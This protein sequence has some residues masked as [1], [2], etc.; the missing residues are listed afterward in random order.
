M[1]FRS[2]S[3]SFRGS[4]NLHLSWG[5][6]ERESKQVIVSIW[7]VGLSS[8]EKVTCVPSLESTSLFPTGVLGTQ[9]CTGI[10]ESLGAPPHL[11]FSGQA[12]RFNHVFSRCPS[13]SGSLFLDSGA[14]G[15]VTTDSSAPVST[16][17]S[18]FRSPTF[19]VAMDSW[20]P[21][22]SDPWQPYLISKWAS[23]TTPGASSSF[24]ALGHSFFQ[25]PK[26]WHQAHWFGCNETQDLRWDRLK[27]R[28][29]PGAEEV[30]GRARDRLSQS[31]G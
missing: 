20:G 30:F 16:M 10:Q 21:D 5:D 27:D 17:K 6:I 8:G 18:M 9:E 1:L 12:K 11:T 23:P 26:A 31:S 24:L 13:Y 28:P 29:V 4:C 15:F 25:W 14:A 3:S 22:I 19:K 7:K 2:T